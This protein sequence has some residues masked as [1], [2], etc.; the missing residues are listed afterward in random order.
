M[1]LPGLLFG[2][3]LILALTGCS[4]VYTIQPIGEK[5]SKIEARDWE[6]TWIHKEGSVT[7]RVM[8]EEDGLLRIAWIERKGEGLAFETHDVQLRETGS[9]VFANTKD[10][11]TDEPRYLWA[12]IKR[13]GKQVIVWLPDEAKFK[14]L[15]EEGKLPGRTQGLDVILDNLEPEH[16]SIITGE[17]E[18]LRFLWDQPVALIRFTQEDR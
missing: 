15:V 6:G 1:K 9:W 5:P 11:D 12:L 8:D 4:A 16:L 7:V 13:D 3:L 17:P 14:V 18:G 2:G 10:D